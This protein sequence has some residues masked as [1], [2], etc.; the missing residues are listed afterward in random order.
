MKKLVFI[1]ALLFVGK[2]GLS[3]DPHFTQFYASPLYLA[4]SFAGSTKGKRIVTNYRNQWPA[5]QKAFVTYSFS[6]DHYLPSLNSGLG[7][8]FLR[9]QAGNGN[10]SMT[11]VGLVYSYHIK[12]NHEWRVIPGFHIMYTQ[13][14]LDFNRLTFGDQLINGQSTTSENAD[15]YSDH[16]KDV[17]A[18]ASALFYSSNLWLG[19]TADHLLQ[20]NESL[21]GEE[22]L[23]SM[24]FSLFGGMKIPINK[25][26]NRSS[27]EELF[28]AFHF[29]SQGKNTQM[30]LGL[31]WHYNP[32]MMGVWYRGIP[33]VKNIPSNDA[34]ALLVGYQID[35]FTV[36]YS[37][38]VTVSHL[39][40][41]TQGAH[42][43]SLTFNFG[44]HK[45]PR[46]KWIPT[47]CPGLNQ[48]F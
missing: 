35:Q 46:E 36:G 38:D 8:I 12:L 32:F 24:R 20:P 29:M 15:A 39:A 27:Q 5:L 44:Q 3:Q 23:V 2:L 9:E 1:F 25:R 30:N 4:P 48:N 26:Y 28:P 17:D 11:N 22:S 18:T 21:S 7:A 6:Y 10:L 13:H 43:I 31:Y 41:L 34:F 45:T 33:L 16:V 40:G 19:L 47:P 14:G 42:E 37:Y